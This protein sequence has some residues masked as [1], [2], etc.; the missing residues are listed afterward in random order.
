MQAQLDQMNAEKEAQQ[1]Q[2]EIDAAVAAALAQQQAAAA[3]AAPAAPP[4]PPPAAAGPTSDTI[5]QLQQLAAL[6]DQGVLTEEEF[7]AQKAKLLGS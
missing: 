7:A 6:K 3:P 2:A 4:P 5:A 1:K